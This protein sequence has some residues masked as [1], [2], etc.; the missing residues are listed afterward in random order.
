MALL[1]SWF[2]ALKRH[3]SNNTDSFSQGQDTVKVPAPPP[4]LMACISDGHRRPQNE[5]HGGRRQAAGPRCLRDWLCSSVSHLLLLANRVRLHT[6]SKEVQAPRRGS[7][8]GSFRGTLFLPP[9]LG[10]WEENVERIQGCRLPWPDLEGGMT[11]EM[12][13]ERLRSASALLSEPSLVA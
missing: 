4:T 13:T 10:P 9:A 5:G 2:P 6:E 12:F 8:L 11:G 3:G 7:S 1:I